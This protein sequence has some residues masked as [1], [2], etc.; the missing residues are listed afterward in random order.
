[1]TLHEAMQQ[2]L[3]TVPGRQ[4]SA[5]DLCERINRQGLYRMQDGRPVEVRQVQAR[6]RNYSQL[7]TALGG[8]IELRGSS[9]ASE[10][11]DAAPVGFPTATSM[12]IEPRTEP[13]SATRAHA[14]PWEG[15]VQEV[16][17]DAIRRHGWSISS[18]ANTAT[19]ERGV[20]VLATKGE[21]RLG[22]EVKGYPLTTYADPRRAGEVKPT[23][24]TLQAGHW[25]SQALG[26]AVMLLDSHE[27]HESL[28]VLPDMPRYR[29]LA[30]R[31]RTGRSRAGVHVVL[32]RPDGSMNSETWS[33]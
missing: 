21:R 7:F 14:W 11:L 18:V 10:P 13:P 3:Q 33:A 4:L 30:H 8:V 5:R 20:D 23:N 1:M 32:V 9:T 22:A 28:M 27:G 26:K 31:T 25:Y 6:A 17:V 12:P 19:K 2:V 16:F 15:A 24:P 29:D